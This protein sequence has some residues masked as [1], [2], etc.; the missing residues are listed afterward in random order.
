MNAT[1]RFLRFYYKYNY[2]ANNKIVAP[3]IYRLLVYCPYLN[4]I[5][6][7]SRSFAYFV[8]RCIAVFCSS[9]EKNVQSIE[10]KCSIA[11]KLVLFLIL[12]HIPEVF[13]FCNWL[14]F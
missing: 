4:S 10:E 2:Y 9:F 7:P 1:F 12:T 5:V 14:S 8:S 3:N 6:R 13:H 11:A